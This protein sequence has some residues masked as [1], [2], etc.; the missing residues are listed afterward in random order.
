MNNYAMIIAHRGN[1][2]GPNPQ[3]E[4]HPDYIKAAI[5]AGFNVELDLRVIDNKCYLGHDTPQYEVPVK[6]LYNHKFWIHAKNIDAAYLL[7]QHASLHWFFHDQDDCTL[8]SRGYLWTY[9]GKQL[10]PS[11]IA[12]MPELAPPGYDLSLCIGVCTDYPQKYLL[13]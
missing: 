13:K 5:E 6:F 11:S 10:T 3:H 9:I 12:V 4:N 1:L 8:T 7:T 2:N